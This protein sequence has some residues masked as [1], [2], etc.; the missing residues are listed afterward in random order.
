MCVYQVVRK[1]VKYV[2]FWNL[3]RM[4]P[5]QNSNIVSWITQ[6][7]EGIGGERSGTCVQISNMS[8][9]I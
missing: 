6:P 1:E 3:I 8:L 7:C 5:E 2:G 4:G 9:F